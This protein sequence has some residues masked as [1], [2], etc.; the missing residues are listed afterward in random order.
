MQSGGRVVSH[1]R[2][3]NET[4]C[5]ASV[6]RKKEADTGVLP[7]HFENGGHKSGTRSFSCTSASVEGKIG[8]TDFTPAATRVTS[9]LPFR[10]SSEGALPT[11]TPPAQAN[12]TPSVPVPG[13]CAR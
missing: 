10:R 6:P 3:V 11:D 12:Q 9:Q 8:N 5:A 1:L 13:R 7:A 2:E 4:L